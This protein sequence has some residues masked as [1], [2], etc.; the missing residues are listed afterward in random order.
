MAALLVFSSCGPDEVSKRPMISISSSD[1]PSNG[2][3]MPKEG[4]DVRVAVIV[5]PGTQWILES[6]SEWIT[7]TIA[8]GSETT[9]VPCTIQPNT[10]GANRT[11]KLTATAEGIPPYEYVVTQLK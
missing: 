3:R 2:T 7:L 10:T 1:I 8:E 9:M 5:Y 4:G 11:A 6:D